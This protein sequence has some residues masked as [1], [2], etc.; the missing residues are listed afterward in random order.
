MGFAPSQ[1]SHYAR[2]KITFAWILLSA[3]ATGE[4]SFPSFSQARKF[5]EEIVIQQ[6]SEGR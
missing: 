6:M 1:S 4:Y 5:S 3:E 2:G